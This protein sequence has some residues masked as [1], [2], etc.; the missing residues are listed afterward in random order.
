MCAG[1]LKFTHQV[2][3]VVIDRRHARDRRAVQHAVAEWLLLARAVDV[4]I[5]SGR[6]SFS[7]EAALMHNVR[8]IDIAQD[9]S[10]MKC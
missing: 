5:R 2:A 6:S 9:G 4:L 8:S 7:A 3:R 1:V 10:V